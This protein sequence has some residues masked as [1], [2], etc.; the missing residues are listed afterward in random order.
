MTEKNRMTADDL[1]A[2]VR[3]FVD[4]HIA[5]LTDAAMAENSFLTL[6]GLHLDSQKGNGWTSLD[7]LEVAFVVDY[8]DAKPFKRSMSI[9]QDVVEK[10]TDEPVGYRQS[11]QA[12]SQ[13]LREL[14]D[15]VDSLIK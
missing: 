9:G 13:A 11:A 4:D 3:K 8:G 1:D 15:K 14:A 2:A 6:P 12:F 5:D 10:I 7:P